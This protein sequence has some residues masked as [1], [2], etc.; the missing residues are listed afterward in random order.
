MTETSIFQISTLLISSLWFQGNSWRFAAWWKTMKACT[1]AWSP[2]S[3]EPSQVKSWKSTSAVSDFLCCKIEITVVITSE[4]MWL[5][6]WQ[7]CFYYFNPIPT[8]VILW[9]RLGYQDLVC[10]FI[11]W[12][13]KKD[14]S[15]FDVWASRSTS[16]RFRKRSSHPE[17]L[18]MA[19]EFNFAYFQ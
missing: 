6:H 13:R 4:F 7:L 19:S 15:S 2:T 17:Q 18:I 1:N 9:F 8:A 16:V 12:I 3:T 10:F 11:N 5:D 14:S